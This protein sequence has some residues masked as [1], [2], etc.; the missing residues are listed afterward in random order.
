MSVGFSGPHLY[1]LSK[2][3]SIKSCVEIAFH[4]VFFEDH[5][6]KL[7]QKPLFIGDKEILSSFKAYIKL[8]HEQFDNPPAFTAASRVR[9]PSAL[10]NSCP[11]WPPY[12][13]ND[14][15]HYVSLIGLHF[16]IASLFLTLEHTK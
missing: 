12:F 4:C 16:F 11:W 8:G 10:R 1:L 3:W 6:A 13:I 15:C 9:S 14:K 7:S 2:L 5:E